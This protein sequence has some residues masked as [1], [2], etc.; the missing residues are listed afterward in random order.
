MSTLKV[1]QI[2]NLNGDVLLSSSGSDSNLT[3]TGELRGP[4]T[5]VIDPAA[6]G[7]NTGTVQIK[8]NLQVDG[9]TTTINS[10]TLSIDDKNIVIA[11]GVSTLA[12]LDTAGIDFGTTAVKLRYNYNAGSNSTLSIEGSNV[13]IGTASAAYTLT[14]QG[15][16]NFTGSLNQN[17][18]AFVASRWTTGT[19]DDIYRSAGDVG[20][21]TTNPQY[22]LDVVGDINF[23]G[24]LRQ[25]GVAFSAG[26]SWTA[27]TGDDIYRS[28]G[29]VGIG[30]TDPT[31]KLH[32]I[33]NANIV[34]DVTVTTITETSSLTL[35]ENINPI[36][37]AIEKILQL[38]PVTYDRKNG[39]GKNEAGLI[40]EE[41]YKIIPNIVTKDSE[42]NPEGINYTKLSV[43][44]IDAIKTL[45]KEIESLK[46]K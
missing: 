16:I 2:Q 18:S 26:A 5:L 35:K 37:N 41:V 45:T 14:V 42:G 4:A 24:T 9:S 43:Y 19:G 33:G 25:N 11:D 34:G 28:T 30:T 7:D 8:G 38:N 12:N 23:T 20:I 29:D 27:G 39:I 6:V 17:G 15:D 21:G 32:V 31:S 36:E 1:N 46:S 44:L 10:T 40:A 3:L 22:K 13:G